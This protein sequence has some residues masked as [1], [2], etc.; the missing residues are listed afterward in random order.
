MSATSLLLM[1]LMIAMAACG[2]G[3]G[4]AGGFGLAEGAQSALAFAVIVLPILR[5]LGMR[6]D[7]PPPAR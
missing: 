3:Q 7:D 6:D 2:H 1:V 5:V 4:D